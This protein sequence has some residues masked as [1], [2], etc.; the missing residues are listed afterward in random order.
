M[1]YLLET[2]VGLALFNEENNMSLVSTFKYNSTEEAI[3]YIQALSKGELPHPITEF[4]SKNLLPL[5]EIN[6]ACPEIVS[7]LSSSLNMKISCSLDGNF[8]GIKKNPFKW[9]ETSKNIY[10]LLTLR[11]AHNMVKTA[12]SDIILI[13]ILDSIEELDTSINN[14]IMRVREWYSLHFP[15]LNS[16]SDNVEYLKYLLEIRNRATFEAKGTNMPEEIRYN[17]SNSMGI[18]MG[19]ND[20]EKIVENV[21]GIKD[22]I[23]YRD[24]RIGLLKSLCKEH[25]PNLFHLLGES[26]TVK[27]IRKAGSI[28]QLA[29]CASSTIQIFGAEKA[30]NQ[31]IKLKSNTPKYGMI[32]DFPLISNA[33][34]E[35]KGKIARI[36]ANK[37]ALCAR[38]DAGIEA[39]ASK[40][41]AA[42]RNGNFGMKMKKK[43]ENLIEKIEDEAKANGKEVVQKKRKIISVKEYNLN[44][45]SRKKA[46]TDIE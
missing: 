25:F 24:K 44:N 14:R 2:P 13:D 19:E 35:N 45:D 11:L 18:E 9:F 41:E 39:S 1:F 43:V 30:F 15:E 8:R 37:I 40:E 27:L 20:I 31:A 36:L 5:S 28:S 7:A 10:N 33:P 23:E 4:L 17:I 38:V 16:V 26:L 6:V 42:N 12:H 34:A 46:K 21:E 22:D 3:H 32:F 29:Q